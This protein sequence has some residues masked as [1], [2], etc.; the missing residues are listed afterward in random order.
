MFLPLSANALPNSPVDSST[1]S[2]IGSTCT[3]YVFIFVYIRIFERL[4]NGLCPASDLTPGAVT[5]GHH[6]ARVETRRYDRGDTRVAAE[7]ARV[8]APR[9]HQRGDG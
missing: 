3:Q 2:R 8:D 7:L 9:P 4:T 1:P 5:D 6:Q